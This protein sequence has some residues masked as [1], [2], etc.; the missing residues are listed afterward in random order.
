MPGC[1]LATKR[2]AVATGAPSMRTSPSRAIRASC[3]WADARSSVTLWRN[4]VPPRAAAMQLSAR[5][6]FEIGR[7]AS[8]GGCAEQQAI[9]AGRVAGVAVDGDVRRGRRRAR[10][11]A[12]RAR[13]LRRRRPASAVMSAPPSSGAPR[14]IS[15]WTR[16]IAG[17]RPSELHGAVAGPDEPRGARV[18]QHEWICHGLNSLLNL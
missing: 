7:R 10:A 17:D 13:P 14:R 8:G 6:R 9:D 18:G 3:A 16:A 12:V 5:D 4:S 1:A 2:S 11:G 15:S